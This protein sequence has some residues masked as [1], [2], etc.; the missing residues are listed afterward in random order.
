MVKDRFIKFAEKIVGA[1]YTDRRLGSIQESRSAYRKPF[2]D[3]MNEFLYGSSGK[4]H[5]LDNR[6]AFHARKLYKEYFTF[7]CK[8]I[9]QKTYPGSQ[10]GSYKFYELTYRD[11]CGRRAMVLTGKGVQE[12]AMRI[13]EKENNNFYSMLP[14][15]V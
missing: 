5:I 10:G 13:Y 4:D 12:Y 8:S 3:E 2:L 9:W 15:Y 7:N 14:V 6:R 11:N 1:R